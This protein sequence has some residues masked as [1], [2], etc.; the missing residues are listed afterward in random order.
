MPT[1]VAVSLV[2][3]VGNA[4]ISTNSLIYIIG[5]DRYGSNFTG[6]FFKLIFT[7]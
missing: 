3:K 7:G 4:E 1:A 6:V 5:P 2:E